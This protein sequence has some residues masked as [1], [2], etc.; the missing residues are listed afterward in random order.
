MPKVL[1]RGLSTMYMAVWITASFGNLEIIAALGLTSKFLSHVYII[2][3]LSEVYS[4][5]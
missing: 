3:P 4:Q 2:T 5:A 1:N